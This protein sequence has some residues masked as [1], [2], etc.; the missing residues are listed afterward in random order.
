MKKTKNKK[1]GETWVGRRPVIFVDRKKAINKK[2]CRNK[3]TF[4]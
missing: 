2:Q 4:W 3:T 1:R